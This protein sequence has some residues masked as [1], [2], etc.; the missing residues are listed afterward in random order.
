M[1]Q[2]KIEENTYELVEDY[3]EGFDLEDFK[4]RYTDYFNDYDY[5]LGDYAYSSLRLKGFCD[6]ENKLFKPL[7]DYSKIK[8][9]IKDSCAYNC[10]YFILKKIK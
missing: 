5:I 9:Y 8:D 2:I 1:K 4:N 6:K 7:N 10:R 3:K